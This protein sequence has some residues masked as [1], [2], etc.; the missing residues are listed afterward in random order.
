MRIN[1]SEVA[2]SGNSNRT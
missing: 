2:F 1:E